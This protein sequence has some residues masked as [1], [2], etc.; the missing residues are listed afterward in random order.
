MV[1]M[2]LKFQCPASM[3]VRSPPSESDSVKQ[4]L[5]AVLFKHLLSDMKS[6]LILMT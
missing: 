4:V 3:F 1:R 6:H 2:Q 5:L